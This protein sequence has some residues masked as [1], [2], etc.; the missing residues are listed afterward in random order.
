MVHVAFPDERYNKH[1]VTTT[2]RDGVW[3]A[4]HVNDNGFCGTT[5]NEAALCDART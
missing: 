5:V 1:K 3:D 4:L 2:F